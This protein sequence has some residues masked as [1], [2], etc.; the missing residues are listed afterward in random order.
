MKAFY[1]FI[2][3]LTSSVCSQTILVQ[4]GDSRVFI[5]TE[6]N[7]TGKNF[8]HVHQNETTALKAARHYVAKN[9][10]FILTLEHSGS[11]NIVFKLKG[12]RYEFDPNRIFTDKGI[13]ATL[14]QFGTYSLEAHQQ[15]KK[16]AQYILINLP[17][18]KVIA[19]HNNMSYSLKNYLP[20]NKLAKDAEQIHLNPK[21]Y[22]R[23]FYFVTSKAEFERLSKLAL[24]TV[25]QAKEAADDGSLSIRLN[26]RNFVN[27]EAGYDQFAQQLQ[28]IETA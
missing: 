6:R 12:K 8:I 16:L 11:R 1:L 17:R 9:G 10:G 15:V 5:K 24:N 21:K 2:F 19:V 14:S 13:I 26:Q 4:I 22:Y 3:L 25:L 7:Y 23:N 18:G 27:V 20:G 28:M